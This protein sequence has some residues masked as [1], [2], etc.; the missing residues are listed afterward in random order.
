MEEASLK[1]ITQSII[2]IISYVESNKAIE[3]VKRSM[4]EGG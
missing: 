3:R 2:S 1:R 4:V